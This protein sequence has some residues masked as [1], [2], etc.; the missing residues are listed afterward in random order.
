MN[1][2][3]QARHKHFDDLPPKN[4]DK[5]AVYTDNELQYLMHVPFAQG[6]KPD[7]PHRMDPKHFLS[8]SVIVG[9]G[10][11]DCYYYEAATDFEVTYQVIK[12]G[13]RDIGFMSVD[14]QAV[15][16]IQKLPA[17]ESTVP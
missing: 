8:F 10:N 6:E 13:N 11:R 5:R 17:P 12:G 9:A 1:A 2:Y 16:V 4:R 15:P 7:G 3:D 14:P